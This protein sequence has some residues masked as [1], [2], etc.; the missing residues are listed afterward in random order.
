MSNRSIVHNL[1]N[2]YDVN[3]KAGGIAWSRKTLTAASDLG[4]SPSATDQ[5][6]RVSVSIPSRYFAETGT[7]KVGFFVETS[8]DIWSQSCGVDNFKITAHGTECHSQASDRV[9]ASENKEVCAHF[10]GDPHVVTFDG[11]KYDCQGEGEFT[12]LK[13]LDSAFEIQA[14]FDSAAASKIVAVTRSFAVNTGEEG[15]PKV[16][17]QVPVNATTEGC[18]ISLFVDDVQKSIETEGTSND[19]VQV[20]VIG[21]EGARRVTIFYPASGLHFTSLL[22][23]SEAYGCYLSSSVC[24]PDDYRTNETFVGLLGSPNGDRKDDWMT[25]QG[26]PV[27]IASDKRFE[28]AYKY[29]T[30]NWCVDQES[31]SLFAYTDGKTFQDYYNCDAPYNTGIE[32]AVA[33]AP[34]ELITMC[35]GDITCI[36]DG[37]AG[38]VNDANSDLNDEAEL[39]GCSTLLF[40]DDMETTPS[41]TWEQ[42]ITDSRSDS[43][44]SFL[45]PFGKGQ[46]GSSKD[47]SVPV[48]ANRLNVEFLLYEIGEWSED[49]VFY[50]VVGETN[51]DLKEFNSGITAMEGVI[52]GVYFERHRI[53]TAGAGNMLYYG[54]S[55]VKIHKVCFAHFLFSF[56]SWALACF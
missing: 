13:S 55:T 5:K 10:W 44:S 34:P 15:V 36:I 51:V 21:S 20:Q 11:L 41:G 46:T 7:L 43:L 19:L 17:I 56:E 53:Q 31:D 25:P 27:M 49:S 18:P 3:G 30:E 29:C 50:V 2:F 24:L 33:N 4:F 48:E 42:G 22:T 9:S 12:L 45:G 37:V 40:F 32:D 6:H 14:R 52:D 38:S 26:S 28:P 23:N 1:V 47:L 39:T 8:H 35:A 54:S 16:Q